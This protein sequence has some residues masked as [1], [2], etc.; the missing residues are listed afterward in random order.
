M[1]CAHTALLI[2]VCVCVCV[3]V[4]SPLLCG[5]CCPNSFPVL[6]TGVC[7]PLRTFISSP[8]CLFPPIR[9]LPL[10]IRSLPLCTSP[11]W[12]V[13]LTVS[14]TLTSSSWLPPLPR[15]GHSIRR[16]LS[17][18]LHAVVVKQRNT[19]HTRIHPPPLTRTRIHTPTHHNHHLHKIEPRY[20]ALLRP[21]TALSPSLPSLPLSLSLSTIR[22][23][24]P[25]P[26]PTTFSS[27]PLRSPLLPNRCNYRH[28]PVLCPPLPP[29]LTTTTWLHA[30]PLLPRG[31]YLRVP[32]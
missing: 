13:P 24:P 26:P 23:R 31:I 5:C 10:C 11:L 7:H 3:C 8:H 6:Y 22:S 25:P 28:F 16:N 14:P 2:C 17:L 4:F 1:T 19:S 27:L 9:S 30:L 12:R 21:S 32:S 29:L 15:S 18:L 20:C